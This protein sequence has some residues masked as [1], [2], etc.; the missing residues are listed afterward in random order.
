LNFN[1]QLLCLSIN[2]KENSFSWFPGHVF[3]IENALI[4]SIGKLP[5]VPM[6]CGKQLTN[7]AADD[8]QTERFGPLQ[9]ASRNLSI[10]WIKHRSLAIAICSTAISP[11]R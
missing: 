11:Y 2:K 3:E 10:S 7:L 4:T 5:V 6:G 9:A 8:C 1:G